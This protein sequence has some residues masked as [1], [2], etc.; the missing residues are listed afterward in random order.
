MTL[1]SA[2]LISLLGA[3]RGLGLRPGSAVPLFSHI[4]KNGGTF[5]SSELQKRGLP[6][7]DTGFR[8][9]SV[10]PCSGWHV[11]VG[12]AIDAGCASPG[13][14]PGQKMFAVLRHP[15]VRAVSQWTWGHDGW[16]EAL[17]YEATASDMN[18][19]I[20]DSIANATVATDEASKCYTSR[21]WQRN[22]GRFVQDCHWLPQSDY[23]YDSSHKE[24][25]VTT[26]LNQSTLTQE[27]RAMLGE[28]A[29]ADPVASRSARDATDN[30]LA[31]VMEDGTTPEVFSAWLCALTEQTKDML[32]RHYAVDFEKF[33]YLFDRTNYAKAPCKPGGRRSLPSLDPSAAK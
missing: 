11:P 4:P 8:C 31:S 16:K 5:V 19:F 33:G 1:F 14:T 23:V 25:L 3:A 26:L 7:F 30:E 15:Y 12:L 2:L 22:C 27:F 20:Q 29:A 9:H 32:D 10:I 17:G 6:Y 18:R 28:P 21:P 24:P 13:Y